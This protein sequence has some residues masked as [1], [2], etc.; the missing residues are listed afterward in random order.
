MAA[1]ISSYTC[2]GLG[3]PNA[4]QQCIGTA[5]VSADESDQDRCLAANPYSLVFASSSRSGRNITC[6]FSAQPVYSCPGHRELGVQRRGLAERDDVLA[7]R[8]IA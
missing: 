1:T 5:I 4:S 6:R 2:N 3:S 7:M 8:A